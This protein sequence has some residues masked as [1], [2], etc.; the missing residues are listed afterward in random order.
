[1]GLLLFESGVELQKRQRLADRLV[2]YRPALPGLVMPL[3]AAELKYRLPLESML[4]RYD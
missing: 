3:P 1:M 4:Q 2:S